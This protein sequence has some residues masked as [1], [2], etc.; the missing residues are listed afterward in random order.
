MTK[1]EIKSL[2]LLELIIREV[3]ETSRWLYRDELK[4]RLK[5][6]DLRKYLADYENDD[7]PNYENEKSYQDEPPGSWTCGELASKMLSSNYKFEDMRKE[8]ANILG[9]LENV[10]KAN[11]TEQ[12]MS[13]PQ[14]RMW[15]SIIAHYR[16]WKLEHA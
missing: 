3:N 12:E 11:W 5:E 9:F 13:Q 6:T 2:P 16:K 10:E 4:L 15:R 14:Y 8:S 1:S 7:Q